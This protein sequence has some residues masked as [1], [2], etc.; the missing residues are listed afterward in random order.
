MERFVDVNMT[1][2]CMLTAGTDTDH[3]NHTSN[4]KMIHVAELKEEDVY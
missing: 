3:Q 1:F 2:A 4:N